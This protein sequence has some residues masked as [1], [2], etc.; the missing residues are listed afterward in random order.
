MKLYCS[1]GAWSLAPHIIL[2]ETGR[3]FQLV[4]VDTTTKGRTKR[5]V[6]PKGYVLPLRLDD[7]LSAT[8]KGRGGHSVSGR[9]SSA[10]LVPATATGEQHQRRFVEARSHHDITAPRDLPRLAG[11]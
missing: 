9:C 10:E 5:P 6:N 3:D 11:L 7:G 4:Q 2:R 1:P 8:L